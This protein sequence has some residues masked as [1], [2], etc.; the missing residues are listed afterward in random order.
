[1]HLRVDSTRE[2]FF[3]ARC[4]SHTSTCDAVFVALFSRTR[5]F[6][7][8][9]DFLDDPFGFACRTLPSETLI[10]EIH[11]DIAKGTA[12]LD[13]PAYVAMQQRLESAE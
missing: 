13:E 6:H 9:L 4:A 7:F 2:E 11:A 1:M 10:A 8:A 3:L 12:A 5:I